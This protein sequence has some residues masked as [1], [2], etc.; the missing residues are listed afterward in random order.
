MVRIKVIKAHSASVNSCEFYDNDQKILTCSEDK[1][2]KC[3]NAD[4]GLCIKTY[5]TKHKETI[6]E[7]RGTPDRSRFVTSSL[8]KAVHCYDAETGKMHWSGIHAGMV[9]CCRVSNNGRLVASGSDLDNCLK[10]WDTHT[11]QVIHSIEDLHSSSITSV[12][13]APDDDKVITTS[14]DRRTMF[15][16]LKTRKVT[17]TLEGHI[18]IV[19]CCDMTKDERRFA[20]GAWDKNMCIWDIATGTYR[21][22]GPVRLSAAHEGSITCCKFSP[23]GGMLVSGS[24]DNNLV[25]WDME[26]E[27]Q[28]IKLQGHS[29]WVEDVCFSQDQRW[30]M[31]CARDQTVRLWN[32]EDSDKIPI[33]L[34]KKR[35]VGVKI[36]KCEQCGKPFSLAQL[37]DHSDITKCVFC[38]VHSSDLYLQ[39]MKSGLSENET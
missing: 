16:D 12:M 18:N 38:R 26:N 5:K 19:S 3:F 24:C 39:N 6:S 28:K 22:K 9:L 8:D 2:V 32:I 37:E 1:T 7:A 14:M 17:I 27:I 23:D 29:G 33:V 15:F 21:S 34:E 11:G 13:F 30:L 35:A 25:V 31:S 10:V 36:Q 4:D 20:T